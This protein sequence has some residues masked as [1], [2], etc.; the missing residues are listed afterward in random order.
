MHN[1]QTG[2]TGTAGILDAFI[3]QAFEADSDPCLF[4]MITE[5]KPWAESQHKVT[6][7]SLLKRSENANR[8]EQIHDLTKGREAGA[9]NFI[10]Q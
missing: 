6:R 8:C 9:L 7:E 3:Y 10:G 2:D 4:W 5:Q 1:A